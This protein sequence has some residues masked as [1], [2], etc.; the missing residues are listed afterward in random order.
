MEGVGGW[1]PDQ[2]GAGG[3]E[4]ERLYKIYCKYSLRKCGVMHYKQYI[5]AETANKYFRG[6]VL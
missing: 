1:T 5:V 6:N 3:A 4:S 2:P